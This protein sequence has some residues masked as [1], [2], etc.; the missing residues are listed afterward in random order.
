MVAAWWGAVLQVAR[1]A[2]QPLDAGAAVAAFEALALC[3]G[4]LVQVRGGFGIRS[5]GEVAGASALT[6]AGPR[7]RRR[8][9][10][11]SFHISPRARRAREPAA[12]PERMHDGCPRS[13][14]RLPAPRGS[15]PLAPAPR[16]RSTVPGTPAGALST[17]SHKTPSRASWP[18][19]PGPPGSARLPYAEN[20]LRAFLEHMTLNALP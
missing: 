6:S 19:R 14:P 18:N 17:R 4:L 15:R 1:F 16:P 13:T 3:K 11:R 9:A 8:G 10:S 7:R 12:A 5:A 20:S 2:H